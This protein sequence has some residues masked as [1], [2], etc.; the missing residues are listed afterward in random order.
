MLQKPVSPSTLLIAFL[1]AAP[2]VDAV[3]AGGRD[4]LILTGLGG[5]AWAPFCA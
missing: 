1:L 2:S 4:Q 5:G 3:V